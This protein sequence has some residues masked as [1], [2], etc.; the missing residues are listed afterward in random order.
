MVDIIK[1]TK[2]FL[3]EKSDDAEHQFVNFGLLTVIGFP[4]FY[5]ANLF[6]GEPIYDNIFFRII[7]VSLAVPLIF[8]KKFFKKRDKF[9]PYYW[10]FSITF[11]LPFFFTF[12]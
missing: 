7:A 11:I 10:Y 8:H 2:S 1:L 3:K 6:T 5:I 9:K 4:L 12:M